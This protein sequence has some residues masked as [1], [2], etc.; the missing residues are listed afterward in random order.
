M[1]KTE[2]TFTLCEKYRSSCHE[3]FCEKGV[4]KIFSKYTEKVSFLIKLQAE[5][6]ITLFYKQLDPEPQLSMLLAFSRFSGLK[7]AYR[8]TNLKCHTV[9]TGRWRNYINI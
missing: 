9:K 7:V 1:L 2:S 5:D 6:F 4:L 8:L 3:V